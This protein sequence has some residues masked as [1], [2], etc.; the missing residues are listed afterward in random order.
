V[1]YSSS[2][3]VSERA[4]GGD[5]DATYSSPAIEARAPSVTCGMTCSGA[6][7]ITWSAR[8][9]QQHRRPVAPQGAEDGPDDAL[10]WEVPEPLPD[11]SGELYVWMAGEAGVMRRLRRL[12]RHRHALPWSAVACMGYWRQGRSEPA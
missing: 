8:L 12:A 7:R 4:V 9:R 6:D 2:P 11:P 5:T 10:L 1:T 3:H